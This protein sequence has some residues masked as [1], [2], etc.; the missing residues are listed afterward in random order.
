MDKKI[1]SLFLIVSLFTSVL[2]GL[3]EPSISVQLLSKNRQKISQAEIGIPCILEVVCQN[4]KPTSELQGLE[5]GI[6]YSIQFAGSSQIVNYINGSSSKEEYIFS[7]IILSKVKGILELGPITTQDSDGNTISSEKIEITIADIAE[8]QRTADEPYLLDMAIEPASA[9]IYLGQKVKMKLS[10]CYQQSFHNLTLENLV[11]D[12]VTTGHQDT[13]WKAGS[14]TIGSQNYSSQEMSIDFFPKK[15]GTLVIPPFQA[16]FIPETLSDMSI[17]GLFGFSNAKVVESYPK[18]IEILP[19]PKSEQYPDVHAIGSFS[20]AEFIISLN[21]GQVG[22]GIHAKMTIQGDGNLDILEHPELILPE[23]VH[24]YQG[25]SSI[26]SIDE[27][28]AKKTFDWI[29]QSDNPGD[30]KIESQVF[31][32]FDPKDKKYKKLHTNAVN[33]K[34]VG[35]KNQ[36]EEK[37]EESKS[38]ESEVLKET[39]QDEEEKSEALENQEQN[40][41]K[42][43]SS[44]TFYNNSDSGFL[45]NIIKL[46]IL[47]IVALF[48]VTILLPYIQKIFFIQT[49]KYRWAFFKAYKKADVSAIY[50]LFEQLSHDY[51]FGLQS[52]ELES[53]FLKNNLSSDTFENWKNFLHMLLE[54]NFASDHSLRDKQLVLDLA[55]QWFSIILLCCKASFFR[56]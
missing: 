14:K 21:Q 56:K 22:E 55:K 52:K 6:N 23:G 31:V 20:K 35:L 39:A 46:L 41:K 40:V 44:D 10:F 4:F 8:P 42:Y 1:G 9:P 3:K 24:F 38:E 29:L 34:I 45:T 11:L 54:F 53:Y 47:F 28:V 32:Y 43:Y 5:S 37:L 18:Q 13:Q 30:F 19:L 16:H 2:F 15:T 33:L 12:E 25:N 51:K 48:L 7:Y 26:E 17:F 50:A 27:N 49:L 36:E